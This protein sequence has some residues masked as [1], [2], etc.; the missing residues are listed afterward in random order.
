MNKHIWI[1]NEYAGSPYHGMEFR[2]FYLA[3]EWVKMGY[4]VTIIS[5]SHSHVFKNQPTQKHEIIHGVE[6]LWLKTIKY[7]NSSSKKRILK[8]FLFNIKLLTLPFKLQKPNI[9]ILSPMAPFPSFF[10]WILAKIYHAKFI[11]EVKDIWPLSII[12]L[13]GF[14]PKHPFI[15]LMS[16]FER[17]ALTHADSIVSNLQNYGKHLEALKIDKDFHWISNGVD[18]EELAQKEPLSLSIKIPKDKFIVG[19]TGAIGKAN[20]LESFLEAANLLATN[21]NILFVVVGDGSEKKSLMQQYKDAKNILFVESIPKKQVQSMLEY[22]DVCYIGLQKEKLF[23][24]GVSPNKLYDY[25][26]SKKPILYA[27]DSGKQNIITKV[28]CGLEAKAQNAQDIADKIVKFTTMT[29]KELENIGIKGY[30]YVVKYF[31]YTTLAKI[32]EE[33]VFNK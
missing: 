1:I 13:G 21:E 26:Y 25:M 16:W 31:N 32:F 6:Y 27:I 9:I 14:S 23:H 15:R 5:S 24:Y 33:N 4:K 19:Y 30:K 11:Y 2:S 12:E 10:S 17:F 20:T 8:W 3:K 7:P 18:L 29:P 22:F 28:G